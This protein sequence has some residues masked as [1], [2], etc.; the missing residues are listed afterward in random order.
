LLTVGGDAPGLNAAVRGFVH[1]ATRQGILVCASHFG[2]AGLLGCEAVGSLRLQDVRGILPRGG[3]ILGCS[4][5]ANPLA[6]PTEDP[7][8][9]EASAMVRART[10]E[11]GIDALVLIGGDGTMSIAERLGGIGVPCIG[12]P[13]TI[14]GDVGETELTCGLDS[15]VETATR[16]ID[17]LHSTA[18]AHQRVMIIECM[19]RYAGFIALRSAIAGGADAVLIPEIPYDVD[20]VVAKIREREHLGLRF[21]IVVIGEGACP[22]G[23]CTSEVEPGGPG[24]L[25]RLGGAG[26]RL[27]QELL[28]HDVRH[29][30][31]V[32][33]LGHLQR[34]GSPTASDRLLATRFGVQ[35]AELCAQ[36]RF[37]RMVA[38]RAGRVDSVSIGEACRARARVAP[39]GELVRSARAI[40]IELGA[41]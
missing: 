15:A 9:R 12:I 26:Q 20:R 5:H 19:G 16:A 35:A 25:P 4:T 31:R 3:S 18:E 28:A 17:A 39:A 27:A 7:A 32:T 23:S 24:R 34:G 30:V 13:K 40:G 8:F 37:G 6:L 29:E 14:D 38:L 21:S 11:L 10:R 36:R 22:A 2:F 33:V 1:A 41:P